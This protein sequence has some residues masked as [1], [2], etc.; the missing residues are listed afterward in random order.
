M[1][2]KVDYLLPDEEYSPKKPDWE[3]VKNYINIEYVHIIQSY[4]TS[5]L[6]I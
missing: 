5:L 3:K 6:P 2:N 4:F 1:N